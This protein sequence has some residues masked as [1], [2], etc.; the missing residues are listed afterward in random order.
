MD[1]DPTT[2]LAVVSCAA[3]FL[4]WLVLP[5]NARPVSAVRAAKQLEKAPVSAA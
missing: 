4:A 3:V 1:L 5:H 2:I